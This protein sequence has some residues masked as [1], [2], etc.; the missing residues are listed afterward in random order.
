LLG[1]LV[2]V[3][4]LS[5]LFE[6]FVVLLELRMSLKSDEELGLLCVSFDGDGLSLDLLEGGV[7]VPKAQLQSK[8]NI[9]D[10]VLGSLDTGGNCIAEGVELDCGVILEDL[11][12]EVHV[13]LGLSLVGHIDLVGVFAGCLGLAAG[14]GV[15]GFH[16]CTGLGL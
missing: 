15:S 7:V 4:L 9:P 14:L 5:E 10:E 11:L 6:L 3:V 2:L 12:S 13:E 1:F 8:S 16:L